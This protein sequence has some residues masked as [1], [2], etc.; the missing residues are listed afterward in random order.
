MA[1]SGSGLEPQSWPDLSKKCSS[2]SNKV[3]TLNP[4]LF[5]IDIANSQISRETLM[6]LGFDKLIQEFDDHEASR[7]GLGFRVDAVEVQEVEA[8]PNGHRSSLLGPGG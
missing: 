4:K 3:K 5:A 8:H 1:S 2:S 6:E 7:E